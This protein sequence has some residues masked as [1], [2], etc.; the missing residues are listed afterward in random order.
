MAQLL[1]DG[2]SRAEGTKNTATEGGEERRYSLTA[3]SIDTDPT[4][5]TADEMARINDYLSYQDAS[6]GDFFDKYIQDK[7][8]PF[9]RHTISQVSARQAADIQSLLGIDVSGYSNA[10]NKNA[11]LHIEDRHGVNGKADQTMR[12]VGDASRIGYILDKYDSV[13][14]LLNND[15]TPTLS[16]DIRNTDHTNAPLVRFEKSIDGTYYVVE[17]ITDAKYKKLWVVS[18]YMAQKNSGAV[19]QVPNAVALGT[20]PETKL[21][22][23]TSANPSIAAESNSVNTSTEENSEAPMYSLDEDWEDDLPISGEEPVSGFDAY[24]N[25]DGIEDTLEDGT[26]LLGKKDSQ[27]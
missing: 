1:R 13:E 17:A 16:A 18:A 12:E 27:D 4:H 14:Q 23:P 6:L 25:E 15:G 8:A 5:H 21:A 2:L 10:I 22:S 24:R 7:N 11:V 3:T 26:R 20:T 19:T 9:S